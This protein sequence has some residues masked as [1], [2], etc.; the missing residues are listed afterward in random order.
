MAVAVKILACRMF[1]GVDLRKSADLLEAAAASVLWE[2]ESTV[3]HIE[4][5]NI[6][7]QRPFFRS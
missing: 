1:R 3:R 2:R 7:R 4:A 6:M 5:S